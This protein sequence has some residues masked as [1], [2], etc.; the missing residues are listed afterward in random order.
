MEFFIV[1]AVKQITFKMD[2]L[3]TNVT[4]YSP[5]VFVYIFVAGGAWVFGR[6]GGHGESD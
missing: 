1:I 2:P 4:K 6:G 3:I 5:V